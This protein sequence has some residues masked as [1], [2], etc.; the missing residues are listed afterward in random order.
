MLAVGA[1]VASI[2]AV[3]TT[4]AAATSRKPDF[5]AQWKACLGPAMADQGFSDVS[6]SGNASHYANIN[7]LAYYGI[8][9]GR[10]A[11]SFAPG[12]NVTRSQMALFLARAA[13][14]ADIDLGE[15]VD[16]GFTDLNADDT[17]RFDA[18]NRVVGAGI[19]F[20]DTETSFDPPSTTV[21]APTDHVTRWEMALFLFAFLDL[22]LDSVLV[23][24]WPRSV[25]GDD[26]ASV[27]LGSDD[28]GRTG[29]R[30]DDY[31]RDAR[32]QTPAHVDNR[33]SAIYELGITT[34]VNN[35][36]GPD[37][38]YNP[39]GLVTRAQ[40]AS[41]I[42]RT[43]GHTNLRPAGLTAQST[44]D[45]TQVSVR[46]ADFTPISD[47]RTEV[48][49]T[50]FPGDA[51]NANGACIA[52]YVQ[53]QDPSFDNCQIDVGDR[54]TSDDIDDEGNAFWEGVGLRS[55]NRLTIPC[56]A[57]GTAFDTYTFMAGT[58]GAD[59][60][61]TIYAWQG[62]IGDTANAPDLFES[63]P[64]NVLATLN[65][66]TKAVITGGV[67]GADTTD[68]GIHVPMGRSVTYM[69]QL[70][71]EKGRPVGPSPD[72]DNSFEVQI[73]TYTEQAATSGANDGFYSGQLNDQ[74]TEDTDDDV[75]VPTDADAFSGDD[76]TRIRDSYEPDDSGQFTFTI[77]SRDTQRHRNNPDTLKRVTIRNGSDNTLDLRDMTGPPMGTVVAG[78]VQLHDVRFSDNAAT[79]RRVA[80]DAADWRL[81]APRNRNSITVTVQDQYGGLYRGGDH[82]VRANDQTNDGNDVA[83]NAADFP[84]A[85]ED[86]PGGYRVSTS[87]RRSIGYTHLSIRPLAQ[88]V[89]LQLRI[90]GISEIEADPDATPPIERVDAV[91]PVNVETGTKMVT[92]Y[93]ADRG[94]VPTDHVGDPILLGDPAANHIV[95]DAQDFDDDAPGGDE[96]T[97][98]YPIAYGYGS[99][100]KFVVEGQVVNMDQFE[101][102]LAMHAPLPKLIAD[103]GTLSWVGYD[104][105]RP[106]D[107]ATWSIDGLSCREPLAGD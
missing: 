73:D 105:N 83:S 36:V 72:A 56:T 18:I 107:G 94:G 67:V 63:E 37:G 20:G 24:V 39:N 97:D 17:E 86:F 98:T 42:M 16:Q 5:E 22:A 23:D 59:T 2:L 99:D 10:T 101:E 8:T 54:L 80:A 57:T 47:E 41:F 3:G 106:R 51:F 88:V 13:D 50:N 53:I 91:N 34:G 31:F 48:F 92:I 30:P 28:G 21:F 55:G 64:A 78:G 69:V 84:G 38:V 7:C 49:T 32:R 95:V 44:Y 26:D 29:V 93:W 71:D 60:D 25:D 85:N 90:P 68:Q 9:K 62:A 87:G 70:R 45:D 4:P 102:I 81:R 79:A 76:F 19:M 89:S 58:R 66:A 12:A 11:D 6:E 43:M 46:D 96:I 65:D 1:L 27:E 35:T 40:M 103:L 74:D 100:D 75:I 77:S 14:V 52:Q 61:Y 33:I 82:E 15:A 104:F